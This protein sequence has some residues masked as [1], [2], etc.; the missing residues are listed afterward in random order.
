MPKMPQGGTGGGPAG[1]ITDGISNMNMRG[2][3]KLGIWT[4]DKGGNSGGSANRQGAG[5]MGSSSSLHLSHSTPNLQGACPSH[6][7]LQPPPPP[8][9]GIKITD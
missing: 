9:V 6:I 3:S 8:H 5:S 2:E 4:A 7:T 1:G